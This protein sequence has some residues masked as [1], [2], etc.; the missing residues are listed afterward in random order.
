MKSRDKLVEAL[1]N[2]WPI[3]HIEVTCDT[4]D[5]VLYARDVS[6]IHYR[7]DGIYSS[8]RGNVNSHFKLT[9]KKHNSVSVDIQKTS[10][11][12]E[13]DMNVTVNE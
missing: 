2:N 1:T 9:N 3:D 5:S 13:I 4:C 10:N 12:R 8:I 6:A 11:V 7:P